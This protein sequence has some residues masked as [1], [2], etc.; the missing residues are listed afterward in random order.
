MSSNVNT[1]PR[2]SR[3]SSSS[4]SSIMDKIRGRSS[5][6]SGASNGRI[7]VSAS[8][9]FDVHRVYETFVAALREP[10][11]PKSP[12]GTQDYIDGYRELLK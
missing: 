9:D 8:N 11:N 7:S 5:T 1:D 12:I 3:S 6:D 10:E 4:I 2:S